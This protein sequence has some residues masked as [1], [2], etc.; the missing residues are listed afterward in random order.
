MEIILVI[1]AV[2][3]T[4]ILGVTAYFGLM[5]AYNKVLPLQKLKWQAEFVKER[6]RNG[7]E[8]L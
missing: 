7:M 8:Q 1:C 3:Q 2:I 4:I 6:K 5:A